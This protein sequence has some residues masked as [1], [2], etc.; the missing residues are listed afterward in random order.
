MTICCIQR[1]SWADHQKTQA[2][3]VW[4]P[5]I[6]QPPVPL[7][8]CSDQA[9][10]LLNKWTA[11]SLNKRDTWY[12]FWGALSTVKIL[13]IWDKELLLAAF[14]YLIFKPRQG[15]LRQA[16]ELSRTL[17]SQFKDLSKQQ[18]LPTKRTVLSLRLAALVLWNSGVSS[19]CLRLPQQW[20]YLDFRA[21]SMCSFP[22]QP[23]VPVSNNL[24]LKKPGPQH[25]LYQGA[26][27]I[28]PCL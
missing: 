23:E 5:D 27:N 1:S 18:I 3:V 11:N 28:D 15:I 19:Q 20:C 26:L 13:W 16:Q 6:F 2:N 17:G 24:T 7:S 4:I 21:P 9:H 14:I 25:F 12:D 8:C 22:T 10:N